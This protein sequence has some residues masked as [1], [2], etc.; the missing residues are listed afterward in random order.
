MNELTDYGLKEMDSSWR[1]A[2]LADDM[3]WSFGHERNEIVPHHLGLALNSM[4]EVGYKNSKLI[5]A[6]FKKLD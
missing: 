6:G 2:R 1:M 5:E 4:A 3:I